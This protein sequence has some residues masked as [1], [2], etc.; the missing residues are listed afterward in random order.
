MLVQRKVIFTKN[1]FMLEV[2]EA[3]NIILKHISLTGT[4]ER[5]VSESL[6]F[7]LA[8]DF[9]STIDLPPFDQSA[10]DGFGVTAHEEPVTLKVVGEIPAGS[11]DS[12]GIDRNSAVRLFTGSAVPPTVQSVVM[13]EHVTETETGTIILKEKVA[14]GINIRY[15]GSQIKA[16]ELALKA[17]TV[18]NPAAIGFLQAL[19]YDKVKVKAKP[20]IGIVVTG[21]ELKQPGQSLSKGEIYESNSQ[22][23]RSALMENGIEEIKIRIAKDEAELVKAAWEEL[24]V[25][26]DVIIFS[27][28]ISVGKY[29]LVKTIVEESGVKTKFHKIAQKPGKPMYFGMSGNKPVFALPGNP[30]AVLTCFYEYVLPALKKMSGSEKYFL[31]KMALP[32]THGIKKKKGLTVFMKGKINDKGVSP[33]DGQESF[34]LRSFAEADCLIVVGAEQE[35]MEA[36]EIAEVHLLPGIL[37]G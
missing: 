22:M 36:G 13:Q 11:S 19:G 24:L 9:F 20:R 15:K 1:C 32:L 37:K 3:L 12:F 28:G 17:K 7:A 8:E 4:E 35:N 29:D 10:V 6:G 25:D 16:G 5:S 30:A 31:P 27:G 14:S 26:S 21:S 34:I 2:S 23:L 18:L 33:L